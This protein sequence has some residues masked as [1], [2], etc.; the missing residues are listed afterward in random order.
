MGQTLSMPVYRLK[1]CCARSVSRL[2]IC[3]KWRLTIERSLIFWW[4]PQIWISRCIIIKSNFTDCENVYS[5]SRIRPVLSS[6]RF[7]VYSLYSSKYKIR[8]L[9]S[10]DYIKCK[11]KY[12]AVFNTISI[13]LSIKWVLSTPRVKRPRFEAD[14]SSHLLPTLRMRRT[15]PLLSHK[16]TTSS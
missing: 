14:N 6:C 8:V 1:V 16:G 2:E 4:K 3:G 5:S 12:T 15:I 7:V 9:F 11:G 10:D 13:R